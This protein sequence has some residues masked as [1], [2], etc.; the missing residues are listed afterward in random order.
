[1]NGQSASKTTS[2]AHGSRYRPRTSGR[3]RGRATR[4]APPRHFGAWLFSALGSSRCLVLLGAWFFSAVSRDSPRALW[5]SRP[6]RGAAA[7]ASWI[8]HPVSVKALDRLAF[9]GRCKIDA[10]HV[11]KIP[12]VWPPLPGATRQLLPRA[13]HP[14]IRTRF[15]MRT[16][17]ARTDDLGFLCASSHRPDSAPQLQQRCSH[18]SVDFYA[19]AG[20]SAQRSRKPMCG[21]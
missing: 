11:Y 6:Y 8:R 1:M 2:V 5:N 19:H 15:S 16:G 12:R 3:R 10:H 4:A 18:T 7:F 9:L 14:V 21:T 20:R 17:P 13:R